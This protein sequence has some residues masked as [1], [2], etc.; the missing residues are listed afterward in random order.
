VTP[1][2]GSFLAASS[3]RGTLLLRV[4]QFPGVVDSWRHQCPRRASRAPHPAGHDRMLAPELT[5]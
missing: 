2:H 5:G 1:Q 4:V 3:G